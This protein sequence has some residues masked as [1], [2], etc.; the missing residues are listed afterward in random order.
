MAIVYE[1][2][3]NSYTC[4]T[5]VDCY[6]YTIIHTGKLIKKAIPID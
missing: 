6:N 4:I 5:V 3:K 2:S 1:L